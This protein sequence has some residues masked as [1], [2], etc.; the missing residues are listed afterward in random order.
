MKFLYETHMH[1]AEVSACA[2]SAAA[3]QARAYSER[4]Y[5][6][7]I[8]TDHFVNGNTTVH[9]K[10]PWE[11]KMKLFYSGYAAVK[12]E[13]EKRGL[14]VFFG[15]EFTI[16]GSDFLTYGL[17]FEFLLKHPGLDKLGIEAYSAIVRESG[18][19]IAQAHP[20]REAWW[21]P[22]PSPADP[23]LLDGVEVYNASMPGEVNEKARLFAETHGLPR[24][25]GSDSHSAN[26]G[27][28]SGVAL[29]KRAESIL[30]IIHGIK[31]GEAELI[32]PR[33]FD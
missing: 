5:A 23:G 1:T 8:V 6:G 4:G 27:F 2:G 13:G 15:W 24:Q 9:Q 31:G 16:R 26:L 10:L 28:A 25:A 29:T 19:Y 33:P 17:D 12:K 3:E 20:Y 22:E 18:G 32:L 7:V 11:K 14:D 30:D 21:I